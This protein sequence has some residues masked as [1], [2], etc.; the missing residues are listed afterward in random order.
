MRNHVIQMILFSM[1]STQY[2]TEEGF[3]KIYLKLALVYKVVLTTVNEKR[4]T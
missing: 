2:L 1:I 4:K 3:A